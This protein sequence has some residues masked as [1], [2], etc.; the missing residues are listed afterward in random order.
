[1]EVINR[2]IFEDLFILDMATNHLGSVE[3]G[4]K[5]KHDFSHVVRFN[6]VRASIK[7]QFPDVENSIE[8]TRDD[9]LADDGYHTLVK[10]IQEAGCIV[11]ARPLDKRSVE[12]CVDLG[13]PILE[14]SG[15]QLNDWL[16]LEPIAR[17][18]KL[19][20]LSRGG[21]SLK[22]M[23]DL[24]A[25][26]GKWNILLA[27]NH[28]V[29]IDLAKDSELEIN[30]I[31]L[32]RSR[33]PDNTIGYST[34]E[35]TNSTNSMMIAY[36]KGA[37]LFERRIDIDSDGLRDSPNGS[38][39]LQVDE[40]F[41]AFQK[42][43]KMCGAPGTHLRMPTKQEIEYLDALLPGVYAKRNLPKGHPLTID[44]VY[45]A[46]PLQKGQLSR[47][48]LTSDDILLKPVKKDQAICIDDVDNQYAQI[49]SLRKKIYNRPSNI[50]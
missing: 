30:Q 5:I 47:R 17:T 21:M 7:L 12:L 31:D 39:P 42:V 34:H 48:E 1:M 44:D 8:K 13:I 50:N 11:T 23:D 27:V 2:N 41:K 15:A 33:Y 32:L 36:A 16:L 49:P 22:D 9:R 35:Y 28:C 19:V 26:F 4:L 43:K 10:A 20:V 24:V 18:R 25:F 37:R 38:V 45:L 14:M 29:S 6:N 46:I 40:W 3:R